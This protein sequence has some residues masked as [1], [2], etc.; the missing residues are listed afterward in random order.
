MALDM[1]A[2][3]RA[4]HC[5]A[6]CNPASQSGTQARNCLVGFAFIRN[7]AHVILAVAGR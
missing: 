2:G 5:L 4:H 7:Q 6:Q 1:D 3:L